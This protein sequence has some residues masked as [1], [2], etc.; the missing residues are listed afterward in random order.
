MTGCTNYR[1]ISGV[2]EFPAAESNRNCI[3]CT[4]VNLF[5]GSLR[6]MIKQSSYYLAVGVVR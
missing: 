3:S 2:A 5:A 4:E 1:E 6:T